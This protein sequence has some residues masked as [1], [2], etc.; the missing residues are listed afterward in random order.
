VADKKKF[1]A[2]KKKSLNTFKIDSALENGKI[3]TKILK[4]PPT[5]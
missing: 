4:I 1:R 3:S 2:H 5:F